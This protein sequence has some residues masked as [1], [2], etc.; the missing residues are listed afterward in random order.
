MRATHLINTP[1]S[2]ESFSD[3]LNSLL[4]II[5]MTSSARNFG[6]IDNV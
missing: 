4:V 1:D 2:I 5:V 3:S 6:A